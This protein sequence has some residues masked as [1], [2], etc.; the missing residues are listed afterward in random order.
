MKLAEA[1]IQMETH[2]KTHVIRSKWW[3]GNQRIEIDYE[4]GVCRSFSLGGLRTF[5]LR[6]EPGVIIADNWELVPK[7]LFEGKGM[8]RRKN[9]NK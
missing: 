4:L 6:M 5:L 7:S 9:K 2:W 1:L 8:D 3:K